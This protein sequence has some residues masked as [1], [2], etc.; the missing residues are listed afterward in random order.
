VKVSSAI[1]SSYA[2]EWKTKQNS[3]RNLFFFWDIASTINCHG[4]RCK[5]AMT[6]AT[7]Q[8]KDAQSRALIFIS[9]P[10]WNK[11]PRN[12]RYLEKGREQKSQGDVNKTSQLSDFTE[13]EYASRRRSPLSSS[14]PRQRLPSS[15]L[16]L[17][18]KKIF[19]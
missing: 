12:E 16:Q 1:N 3:E 10:P 6:Q 7:H 4:I 19:D 2:Q 17:H 11:R 15:R 18:I 5:T 8:V 13:T 14:C 9:W